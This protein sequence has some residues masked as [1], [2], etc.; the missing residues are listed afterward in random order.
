MIEATG[1][2]GLTIENTTISNATNAAHDTGHIDVLAELANH[3]RQRD[4]PE[5]FVS[6]ASGGEILTAKGTS[7]T[8]E[9]AD[10]QDNLSTIHTEQSGTLLVSDNSSLT[11]ASPD[12]IDNSGTIKLDSTGDVTRLYFRSAGSPASTAADRSSCPTAPKTSSPSLHS[13]DQ[14][15]NFDNTISGSGTIGGTADG[16]VLVNDGIIDADHHNA[17]LTLDPAIVDQYRHVGSDQPRHL[18][19][20]R[21]D[22]KQRDIHI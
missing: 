17:A 2:G 9:T 5:W 13:G 8:I 1:V 19:D 15:T 21:H 11:L 22:R 18:G 6:I 12:A 16:M 20:Q 10:G 3:S 4:H 7:N 14:L